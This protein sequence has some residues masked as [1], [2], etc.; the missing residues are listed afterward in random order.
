MWFIILFFIFYSLNVTGFKVG[1]FWLCDSCLK[2][3]PI[4]MVFWVIY[5]IGVIIFITIPNV[6]Q[7]ILLGTFVLFHVVQWI[8]TYRFWFK[9]DPAKI[10]S[11]NDYFAKYHHIIKARTDVLVPDT[12]HICWF[13]GFLASL[14][15]IVL[16]I[17]G[18]V[19]V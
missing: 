7:W 12:I 18:V 14:I 1:N 5:L 2:D 16:V 10:T 19:P 9:K 6:G 11:Y 17:I 15:Y 8:F 3:E 4:D 13:I